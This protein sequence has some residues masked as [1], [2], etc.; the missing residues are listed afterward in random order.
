MDIF[1][2]F[3]LYIALNV[4]RAVSVIVSPTH[5]VPRTLHASYFCYI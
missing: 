4:L 2:K 1:L 3:D 5:L